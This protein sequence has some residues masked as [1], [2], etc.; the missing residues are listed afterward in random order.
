MGFVLA[1]G[2]AAALDHGNGGNAGKVEIVGGQD[3]GAATFS[4]V[5]GDGGGWWAGGRVG[6]PNECL[7]AGEQGRLV[8]LEGQRIVGP[9]SEDSAGRVGAAVERIG[10]D[11]AAVQT[12][13]RERLLGAEHLVAARCQPLTDDQP[14]LGRPDVDQVQRHRP[15]AARI[16]PRK[17]F[18]S[19][20]TTPCSAPPNAF[21]NAANAASK[22]SGA[23]IRKTRL[24]VSWLGPVVQLHHLSQHLELGARKQRHLSTVLR[25]A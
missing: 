25:P 14:G 7:G 17:A 9:G 2:L 8:G 1:S 5:V 21:M 15:A 12:E 3:D 4:P 19:I 24:N 18:P 20:A 10:G 11:D 22:G 13:Q 6:I 23:I 16:G